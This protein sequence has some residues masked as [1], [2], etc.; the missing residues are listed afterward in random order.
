MTALCMSHL[1]MSLAW[2]GPVAPVQWSPLTGMSH[3][4][5]ACHVNEVIASVCVCACTCACVYVCVCV[6]CPARTIIGIGKNHSTGAAALI[7]HAILEFLK[8]FTLSAALGVLFALASAF[9]SCMHA[10]RKNNWLHIVCTAV[11]CSLVAFSVLWVSAGGRIELHCGDVLDP[12][13]A[14]WTWRWICY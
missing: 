12:C 13:C 14:L 7:F 11:V 8:M 9:V 3:Q 2:E 1:C 5:V 4:R 6:S 10:N